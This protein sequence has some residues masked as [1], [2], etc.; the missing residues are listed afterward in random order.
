MRLGE[1]SVMTTMAPMHAH[2]HNQAMHVLKMIRLGVR[3][4]AEMQPKP[5]RLPL[6]VCE[7][8]RARL[9]KPKILTRLPQGY[10]WIFLELL[11]E[12]LQI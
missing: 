4:R 12:L 1:S 2:V 10:A 8:A 9:D 3:V 11:M 6:L 5:H 7:S